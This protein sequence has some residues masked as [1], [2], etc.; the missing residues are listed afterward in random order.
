LA[1]CF[2]GIGGIEFEG[3]FEVFETGRREDELW[4]GIFESERFEEEVRYSESE[5]RD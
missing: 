3:N 4:F 2:D 1:K 5:P